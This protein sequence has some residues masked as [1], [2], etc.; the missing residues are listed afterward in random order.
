MATLLEDQRRLGARAQLP[1]PPQYP[2]GA[3][4]PPTAGDV[5]GRRP[6][7]NMGMADVVPPAQ[8]PPVQPASAVPAQAT[9]APLA[10]TQL[11]AAKIAEALFRGFPGNN[12]E[13]IE[14]E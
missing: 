5:I 2:L 9:N 7:I 6:T 1:A 13:T 11:G 4:P 12:G 3:T 10:Q 14:V 8:L